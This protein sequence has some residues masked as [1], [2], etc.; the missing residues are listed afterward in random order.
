[1][2]YLRSALSTSLS[3]LGGETEG[4]SYLRKADNPGTHRAETFAVQLDGLTVHSPLHACLQLTFPEHAIG[5]FAC[6]CAYQ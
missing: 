2:Y 1:M 3:S 6:V 5:L 4:R